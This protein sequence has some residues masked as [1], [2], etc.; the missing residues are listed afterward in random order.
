MKYLFFLALLLPFGLKAQTDDVQLNKKLK[1]YSKFKLERTSQDTALLNEYIERYKKSGG[2]LYI[3]MM[4]QDFKLTKANDSTYTLKIA[5]Q[6]EERITSSAEWAD[7]F[8]CPIG[9]L[10]GTVV[11]YHADGTKM[12]ESQYKN[13]RKEGIETWYDASGNATHFRYMNDMMITR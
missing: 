9:K 10:N 2:E 6:D 13:E 1:K 12:R 8:F 7:F 4:Q 11:A 5:E 3:V